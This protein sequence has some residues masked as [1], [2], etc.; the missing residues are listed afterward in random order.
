MPELPHSEW[1]KGF[2]EINLGFTPEAAVA[3]AER[4]LN[5]GIC[6]EC[7]QCV[8]ACKAGAIEHN[9]ARD[10]AAGGGGRDPLTPGFRPFDATQK[11][12]YGFGRYPNVV[13]SLQFERLL[14]ATG[15]TG[16]HVLRPSDGQAPPRWP[17]SSA[18]APGMPPAAGIT[19]PMSAACMPPNRP[20]SPRSMIII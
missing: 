16:G 12:E 14:S 1:V 15:P 20:S 10:P 7:L 5:C 2:Q 9:M 4:C 6:S 18:S 3:E 8:A 17:G 13:T 19:A 11:P